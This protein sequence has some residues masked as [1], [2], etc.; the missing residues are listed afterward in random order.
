SNTATLSFGTTSVPGSGNTSVVLGGSGA[1]NTGTISFGSFNLTPDA[2][3]RGLLA[4]DNTNTITITS[5]TISASSNVAVEITRSSS[6][7]PLAISLTSV[8]ASGGTN[9]IK[10]TNVSGSFTITG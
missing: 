7:T 10:L 8:S 5:G 9:G 6:T 4:Q 2:G 3:Q 1:G